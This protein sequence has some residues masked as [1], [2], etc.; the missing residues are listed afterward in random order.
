MDCMDRHKAVL[1]TLKLEGYAKPWWKAAKKTFDGEE[2]EITWT[3]DKCLIVC[4]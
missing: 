3:F 2:T 1:A 4:I